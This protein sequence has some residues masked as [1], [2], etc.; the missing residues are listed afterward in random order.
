M[1]G[2]R[3]ATGPTPPAAASVGR[4]GP[5]DASLAPLRPRRISGRTAALC[6]VL[7]ALMLAYA[8]PMRV[9]FAQQAQISQMQSDQAEQQRRRIDDLA[10]RV[11]RWKD[12]DY[13]VAQIRSRLQ[14]VR[15][16]ELVYFVGAIP[17]QPGRPR[18]TDGRGLVPPAVVGSAGR[19]RSQRPM[20]GVRRP[21]IATLGRS[22]PS[23]DGSR[24]DPGGW[25]TGARAGLPDVVETAPPRRRHSVPDALL[26]CPRVGRRSARWSRVD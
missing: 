24:G 13:L 26:T 20:T 17:D 8:Y 4:P 14:M 10:A 3:Q 7:L 1:L 11:E 16:G 18:T 25:R 2:R 5:P 9:Y 6:V 22:R 19:R 12:E 15:E 21:R 23:W